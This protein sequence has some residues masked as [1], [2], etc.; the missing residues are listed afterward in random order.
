VPWRAI[1]LLR[2]C[3]AGVREPYKQEHALDV[4]KLD[5]V[6]AQDEEG[7]VIP[8]NQKN[9]D[10]YLGADGSPSTITVLGSESKRYRQ[11]KDSIQRRS[12]RSR[13]VKMEPADLLKNRIDLAAASV[14]DWSG[15]EDG[16][17]PYPCTPENAKVLFRADHILEQVEMGIF[18]H[19]DFFVKPSAS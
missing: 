16:T 17:K 11:T 7:S 13:S 19:A 10:P 5:A 6:I 1:L 8:I 4:S 14:I 9:G 15:W 18:A 12:M 3:H 2:A